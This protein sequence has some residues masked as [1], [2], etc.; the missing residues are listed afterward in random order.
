[1]LLL[2]PKYELLNISRQQVLEHFPSVT[3]QHR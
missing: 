2:S 3:E 1:M